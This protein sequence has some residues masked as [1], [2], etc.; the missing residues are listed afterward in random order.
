MRWATSSPAGKLVDPAG[1]A[2]AGGA[3]IGQPHAQRLL[4][5][6][7]GLDL[8]AHGVDHVAL[9][10]V[11]GGDDR[12]GLALLQRAAQ[13]GHLGRSA[14]AGGAELVALAARLVQPAA[15]LL[16]LAAQLLEAL[17][18]LL[19]LGPERLDAIVGA[20][21]LDARGQGVHAIVGPQRLEL[22]AQHVD[23]VV[24]AE[25]LQLGAQ[26][27]H[28]V[29]GAE[30]LDP[31]GQR[32]D[33]VVG[34]QRLDLAPQRLDTVVG[35]ERVDP[36]GQRV[37]AIVG[38][39]RVELL[40]ERLHAVVGA[41][42][43]QLGAQ[44]LHAV[45]DARGQGVDAIVGVEL[46]AQLGQLGPQA[47]DLGGVGA[48]TRLLGA[49]LQRVEAGIE[50]VDPGIGGLLAQGGELAA[51]ALEG[52]ELGAQ[53]VGLLAQRL[54]PGPGRLGVA[55][56]VLEPAPVL[57]GQ[58]LGLVAVDG[59]GGQL[60]AQGI[61]L[62]LHVLD[63]LE[64]GGE[65]GTGGLGL[66]GA[67]ALEA[68]DGLR[69]LG[70][71]GLG[72]LLVLGADLL[73][74]GGEL[75]LA[76]LAR[77]RAGLL[78]LR[79]AVLDGGARLLGAAAG[80]LERPVGAAVGLGHGRGEPRVGGGGGLR[81]LALQPV[82]ALDQLGARG[83]GD[84]DSLV[85]VVRGLLGVDA[86]ALEALK[87]GQELAVLALVHPSGRQPGGE[88]A[89]HL[90]AQGL[91]L[92]LGDL[93]AALGVLAGLLELRRQA[94]G[95]PLQLVDPLHGRQ[96]ARHH[97][98]RVVQVGD[99]ALDT[100]VEVGQALLDL[101]V[102]R[103]A[104]GLAAGELGL[105]PRRGAERAED[106]QGAG[107]APALPRLGHR[108]ERLAQRAHHHG[109]LLAH[110]G[111]H[112]V[113]RELEAEVLEEEREVEALVELDGDEDS[114]HRE[115]RRVGVEAD[116]LEQARDLRRLGG[117]QEPAPRLGGGGDR[118]LDQ[119]LEEGL[120]EHLGRIAAEQQLGGL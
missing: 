27:L 118:R 17:E 16:L 52:G 55:R 11:L 50:L 33:A 101:G 105:D 54:D 53:A 94:E 18:R 36:R 3:Q 108:L 43:V 40:A 72:G 102:G 9:D 57:A 64:R 117:L 34:P 56:Q 21:G 68:G 26:R 77:A 63:A 62:A 12:V 89:L 66:G 1:G 73:Q 59:D 67:V 29:V 104:L 10:D 93:G 85:A 98:G 86:G 111:Q 103:G 74:L 106:D 37:H 28:A 8:A 95:D 91:R 113:H 14:L 97:G 65:L 114:L 69:E 60:L 78:D 13:L 49:R 32:L 31:G 48:G 42:R 87:A 4:G 30:R 46:R 5:V 15:D 22:L 120:P 119:R 92:A 75:G 20:Q 19:V 47:V 58:A 39:Q 45:V 116:E 80:L 99:R 76:D 35:A 44:R 82:Q 81:P 25:G 88:H 83:L 96:Q 70:A 79:E 2:L 51:D 41:Q 61:G 6:A 112:Q 84:L 109:V 7:Q 90:G 110:A 100:R 71:G 115:G 107:R 23:A 38:S 24:G